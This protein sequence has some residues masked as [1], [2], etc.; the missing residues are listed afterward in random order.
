MDSAEPEMM[1]MNAA[2]SDPMTAS[3]S[4]SASSEPVHM[5][6]QA[7]G[8]SS[9]DVSSGTTSTLFGVRRPATI[10][11]DGQPH[12]LVIGREGDI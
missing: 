2:A 7:L 3:S 10:P 12:K 8:L 5:P 4:E 11:S 9:T 1:M 6:P